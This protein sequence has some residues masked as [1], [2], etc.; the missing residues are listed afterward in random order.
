M[1][2]PSKKKLRSSGILFSFI[3]GI[4]FGILPFLIHGEI[5]FMILIICSFIMLI[6]FLTP[7]TLKTPY[8]LWL[9]FGMILGKI[10]SNIILF[11]FFYFFITPFAIM[12]RLFFFSTKFFRK[13][14]ISYY[15][16]NQLS[17]KINFKD[18]F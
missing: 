6:S 3:F 4:I 10:N 17:K 15:S 8:S 5:R 7:Y 14:G 13:K 9:K 11:L 12:R 18:Q 2:F 1:S 16:K